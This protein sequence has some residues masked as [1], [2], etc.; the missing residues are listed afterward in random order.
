MADIALY[1]AARLLLVV[2]LGVVI[3]AV[4][5]LFGV[6]DFPP[7]VA[8]LFAL[9]LALPLGLWLF[10]PLRRRATASVAAV[11]E[12]RRQ[13]REQLRARLSGD[14]PPEK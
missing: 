7:L 11:S 2:A 1:A 3:Y 6:A 9:V 13:D 12:Q 8:V 14:T 10:T 5:R 4:G